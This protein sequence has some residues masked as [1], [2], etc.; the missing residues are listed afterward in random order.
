MVQFLNPFHQVVRLL[1][2]T[3]Y[4]YM[5]R[6]EFQSFASNVLCST[7]N[8]TRRNPSMQIRFVGTDRLIATKESY[9]S[10]N[11]M[12]HIVYTEPPI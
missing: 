6:M 9:K 12:P 3:M 7:E 8:R 1:D 5:L 10:L 4:M 11:G 2:C